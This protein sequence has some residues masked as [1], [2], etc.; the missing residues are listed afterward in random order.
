MLDPRYRQLGN[1]LWVAAIMFI[2][3]VK[4]HG[5]LWG[6]TRN[7]Q[8]AI[9]GTAVFVIFALASFF[10]FGGCMYVCAYSDTHC[11]DMYSYVLYILSLVLFCC[12]VKKQKTKQTPYV[13]PI[14]SAFS[15]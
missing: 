12:I 9:R 5:G 2:P 11:K 6:L 15:L 7:P 10:S 3:A 13:L 4:L 14:W 8:V 1:P